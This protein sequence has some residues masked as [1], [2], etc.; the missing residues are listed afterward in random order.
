MDLTAAAQ[1]LTTALML[2]QSVSANPSLPQSV[3]DQALT[4]AERAITEATKAMGKQA[5]AGA[6]SCKVVSDKYNYFAGEVVVLDLKST[7]ATK[8]EFSQES[9]GVFPT[10]GGELLGLSGQYRKQVTERGYHFLSLK[11][12]NATGQSSLCSAMVNVY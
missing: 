8:L 3:R 4:T 11:A 6:P 5:A 2:L 9:S 7:N 1:L 12:S 10:P